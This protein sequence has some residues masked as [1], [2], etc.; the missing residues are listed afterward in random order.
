MS[1]SPSIHPNPNSRPST[2]SL[3][4][5]SPPPIRTA[6]PASSSSS[7]QQQQQ[8]RQSPRNSTRRRGSSASTSSASKEN[9]PITLT[10]PTSQTSQKGMSLKSGKMP[11]GSGNSSGIVENGDHGSISQPILEDGIPPNELRK[12]GVGT[13]NSK[14]TKSP[15]P[16]ASSSKSPLPSP[17]GS[18]SSSLFNSHY[19]GLP[20]LPPIEDDS[21]YAIL[22]ESPNETPRGSISKSPNSGLSGFKPPPPASSTGTASGQKVLN[23]PRRTSSIHRKPSPGVRPVKAVDWEIPRKTL[24]SSIGT[25]FHSS[26]LFPLPFLPL[27]ISLHCCSLP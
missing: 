13:N 16:I 8:L 4:S 20:T 6:S 17:S 24:H 11:N 5:I 22:S 27:Q 9:I 1:S 19:N 3:R 12:R 26:S 23:R 21:D 2:R 15:S 10:S 18:T 7:S 25:F 14:I